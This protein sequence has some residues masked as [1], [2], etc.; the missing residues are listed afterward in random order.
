MHITRPRK[1]RELKMTKLALL[2]T[3]GALLACGGHKRSAESETPRAQKAEVKPTFD[4]FKAERNVGDLSYRFAGAER[5]GGS[6]AIA[7]GIINNSD[8][9]KNLSSL[10]NFE[11][12]SD[13]GVRGEP[14]IMKT[15]CDGTIPPHGKY[16]CVVSYKFPGGAPTA[17]RVRVQD[18]LVS[19]GN[20]FYVQ[21]VSD[22]KPRA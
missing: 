2:V 14:D 21:V 4:E 8:E 1:V 10:I 20:W 9:E 17:V 22:K 3:I 7:F 16:T 6:V 12:S 15:K 19:N 13:T 11:A 5:V 18:G